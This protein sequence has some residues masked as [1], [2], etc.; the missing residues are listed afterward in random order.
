MKMKKKPSALAVLRHPS[1][2]VRFL[3]DKDAPVLPRLL[4]LFAVLYVVLPVDLI[5]DVI[6]VIG[7]L[8]DIGVVAF[9]LAWTARNV[10][11]Y[12]AREPVVSRV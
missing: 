5:P 2:L 3:R 10:A 8:D 11:E 9:A 12:A 1:A 4:A 7:W 6:P